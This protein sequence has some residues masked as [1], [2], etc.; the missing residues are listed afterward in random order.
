MNIAQNILLLYVPSVADTEGHSQ[1]L[2]TALPFDTGKN[3]C[4][5]HFLKRCRTIQ[6]RLP[7]EQ[8]G[9]IP[10]RML[11][12]LFLKWEQLPTGDYE[13]RPDGQL[14]APLASMSGIIYK[15]HPTG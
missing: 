12:A 9:E 6:Q 1:P 10:A 15:L 3:L 2:A 5:H 8:H 7:R 13:G 4:H 14:P 11:D